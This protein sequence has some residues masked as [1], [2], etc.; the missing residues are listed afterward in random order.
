MS[1]IK[2]NFGDYHYSPKILYLGCKK[3]DKAIA[4]ENLKVIAEIMNGSGLKWGPIFGTLLGMVR[5]NDFIDW[6][7][8]IDLYVMEEDRD[9]FLSLLFKFRDA[10]FEAVRDYRSGVLSI[11][12]NGEY[13][14]FYFLKNVGDNIRCAVGEDYFFDKF[15]NDTIC[16]EFKGVKLHI[17]K[18]Y[19]EY[20][21]FCY[22]D[23]RTPVQSVNYE[24]SLARKWMSISKEYINNHIPDLF[25]YPLFRWHH[26]KD[27][28]K[29][30]RQC[31]DRGI[32]LPEN[33]SLKNYHK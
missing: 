33:L 32:T 17:P 14:D 3:I 21:E 9:D 8:D 16:R 6:D 2:T 26:K 24:M 19:E 25:Y 4:S 27:L 1:T 30:K 18:D 7:E 13:I 22:G 31:I 28:E 5:D 11:M 23:W 20:L 12:K 15:F 29:F 10:G